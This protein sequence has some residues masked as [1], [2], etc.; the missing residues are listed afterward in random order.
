MVFRVKRVPILSIRM[1]LI[2]EYVP[3][4]T[5]LPL[6]N[7]MPHH[8]LWIWIYKVTIC[9]LKWTLRLDL[10]RPVKIN[11]IYTLLS[12]LESLDFGEQFMT[13]CIFYL[14]DRG[15]FLLLSIRFLLICP[16]LQFTLFDTP[17][18][19]S[20]FCFVSWQKY[21]IGVVYWDVEF[22]P[23][24]VEKALVLFISSLD[25]LVFIKNAL[26]CVLYLNILA[27]KDIFG[28]IECA[29]IGVQIRLRSPSHRRKRG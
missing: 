6:A 27:R 24:S 10:H 14:I 11:F 20:I 22:V 1:D 25:A 15:Y 2:H 26:W 13:N 19:S 12:I 18:I 8:L 5:E 4:R 3:V 23:E 29:R 17:Y 16:V 9:W 7:Q 21:H 28:A